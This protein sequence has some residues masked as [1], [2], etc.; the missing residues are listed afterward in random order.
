[1][2][3]FTI[4]GEPIAQSRPRA[5]TVNGHVRM[6]DKK[7]MVDYKGFI[8]LMASQQCKTLMTGPLGLSIHA[9][10]KMPKDF[11]KKKIALAISKYLYPSTKPDADN[12]AKSVMDA[13]T[14]IVWA[15]DGCVVELNVCKLYS[16]KPRLEIVVYEM[17][18]SQ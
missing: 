6:Y 7:E 2:I 5:T 3:A 11:S 4:P 18:E 1:M 9:Y 15:D 16:D 12:Y 17:K 8:K 10:R 13:L 14:G